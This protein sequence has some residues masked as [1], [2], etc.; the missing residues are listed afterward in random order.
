M[1]D[2]F[3][4]F[5]KKDSP[6]RELS[7]SAVFKISGVPEFTFVE[8][9]RISKEIDDHLDT[10]DGVLLFLG[11]SKSGKTVFRK[12]HIANKD[13]NLVTYRGNNSS[14]ISGLYTQ[15]A[16]QLNVAQPTEYQLSKK[17]SQS[18]SSEGQIGNNNV[19]HVKD[20]L[21]DTTENNIAVVSELSSVDIDVNFLCNKLSDSNVMVII[22]DYHLVDKEFNKLLSE[23]LKHFLDEEILFLLI[24]IPSSPS[25]AL[26]NNP[27]LSGRMKHI[28]FDYLSREEVKEL[29]YIGTGLLN[30]KFEEDVIEA[31][32][33]SSLKN[34]YLVQYICRVLVKSKGIDKTSQ[35]NIVFHDPKDVYFAC[36]SIASIL[37]ND[38]SST[39]SVIESGT[40]A[41]KNDKAFN[42]Y[43]EVLKAIKHFNIE[44]WE[45]GVS[46]STI[47][48][49]A[50]TNMEPEKIEI[51]IDNGTYKTE[52]TFKESIRSSVKVAIDKINDNLANNATK[53]IIYVNDGT[54][55]LTDLI[56]K[57]YINWKEQ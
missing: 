52:K 28:S 10:K 25:R 23:D 53:Q 21:V 45:K 35:E 24:G 20:T 40:R 55:Y 56:F 29:I 13:F 46:A 38:Y 37:D 34:P 54:L 6:I 32:I 49:W 8:R 43:E 48:S 42:Q 2:M 12:K 44:E 9:S 18:S 51:Y 16:A 14:T 15:I 31:I 3:K 1:K 33:A 17:A 7:T 39:Y 22:E 30:V 19:G 41:Q 36:K 26:R 5:T 11:Y 47:S 4:K 27:D 50:W 57:F